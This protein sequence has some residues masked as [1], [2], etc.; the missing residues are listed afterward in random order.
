MTKSKL[1]MHKLLGK[2]IWYGAPVSKGHDLYK[3]CSICGKKEKASLSDPD[4]TTSDFIGISSTN[5][6]ITNTSGAI[7]TEGN[8]AKLIR[9]LKEK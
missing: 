1:V 6:S 3:V 7:L 8:L 2:H 5:G 4:F 9:I